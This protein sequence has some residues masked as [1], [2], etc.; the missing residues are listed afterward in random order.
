MKAKFLISTPA[1]SRL[2][3]AA[4][5][6]GWRSD[7]DYA[8]RTVEQVLARSPAGAACEIG[9]RRIE[10][11]AALSGEF[12]GASLEEVIAAITRFFGEPPRCVEAERLGYA[13]VATLA[14][15]APPPA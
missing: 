13:V 7:P 6:R 11:L 3:H 15:G 10:D 8:V 4:G 12:P 9:G 2:G 14:A 5:D 1:Y